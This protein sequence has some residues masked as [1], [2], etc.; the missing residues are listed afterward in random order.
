MYIVFSFTEKTVL[1]KFRSLHC[2]I[3]GTTEFPRFGILTVSFILLVV[4]VICNILINIHCKKLSREPFETD[5][6][7]ILRERIGMTETDNGYH[8]IIEDN[9]RPENFEMGHSSEMTSTNMQL[10]DVSGIQFE[11]S[12]GENEQQKKMIIYILTAQS[13]QIQLRCMKYRCYLRA[14]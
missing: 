10:M 4:S 14:S 9:I 13:C 1:L 3:S 11:T 7:D 6:N 8:T 12:S 2:R 5:E